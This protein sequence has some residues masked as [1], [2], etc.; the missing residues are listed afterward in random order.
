[1]SEL[2]EVNNNK[3]RTELP[4]LI[5]WE[6]D[7]NNA[8]KNVKMSLN[9]RTVEVKVSVETDDVSKLIKVAADFDDN[10]LDTAK[11]LAS[12]L[13]RGKRSA[14]LVLPPSQLE[15]SML[16]S[17]VS[18]DIFDGNEDEDSITLNVSLVEIDF[19]EVPQEEPKKRSSTSEKLPTRPY[20][21]ILDA[22][23]RAARRAQMEAAANPVQEKVAAPETTLPDQPLLAP[24]KSGAKH[25]KIQKK[26]SADEPLLKKVEPKLDLNKV[27]KEGVKE[28]GGAAK[29]I[30]L[31]SCTSAVSLFFSP[32]TL[33]MKGMK[34][35]MEKIDLYVEKNH[36]DSALQL[37]WNAVKGI[38][39]FAV[40]RPAL[41]VTSLCSMIGSI[42]DAL[43]Y[44][45]LLF[46][47]AILLAI[48]YGIAKASGGDL[49]EKNV[50]HILQNIVDR[51]KTA[52]ILAENQ[53][54]QTVTTLGLEAAT[55]LSPSR[56]FTKTSWIKDAADRKI[57][58]WTLFNWA[59]QNNKRRENISEKY[60]FETKSHA[61]YFP[62]AINSIL[63]L[64]VNLAQ[65]F[66]Y[67]NGIEMGSKAFKKSISA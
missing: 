3:N 65:P 47:S 30:A 12:S 42:A 53:L 1:M 37:S 45:V 51:S 64:S 10:H 67:F 15:S 49:L 25:F 6:I 5:D 60:R 7:G 62:H 11:D 46:V 33:L 44:D 2:E 22:Q 4:N 29:A 13:G 41:F 66:A 50:E 58:T 23:L 28:A 26:R 24:V 61:E 35:L 34:S 18:R 59:S 57:T 56:L 54:I 63:K 31:Y 21:N 32:L 48:P 8:S 20:Q 27:M 55:L 16:A 14:S 19:Q 36:P 38:L 17:E 40:M 9:G 43:I 52:W 39:N